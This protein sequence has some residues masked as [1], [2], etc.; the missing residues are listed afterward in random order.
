MN[1]Q[2]PPYDWQNIFFLSLVHVAAVV[3]LAT[4]LPLHGLS[5]AA[6]FV[7]ALMT[8]LT[9]FCISAGYHRLFS[10][11][12]YESHP[13]FRFFLLAFGAGAFQNSALAWATDHRRHHARTDTDLDPYS[14]NGGFWHA[15]VG[16]VLRKTDESITP[17][18]V[19]DLERDPLVMWQA[20]HY[21]L[22]G[23]VTGVIFPT[24]LGWA[25]G[26]A[27][28][29]FV[30]GAA[31]RLMVC[32]H[33][34]FSINSLAHMWGTQPYSDKNSSRDSFVVALISMGEGYHNFHH[35][36]PSDY[37]NGVRRHQFDPTKWILFGLSSVGVVSNLRR[38]SQPTIVRARVRMDERRLEGLAL[39]ADERE[40]LAAVRTAI[41]RATDR[42]HELMSRYET[43]KR[44]ASD[45]ARALLREL[46]A[47]LRAAQRELRAA[48][49]AW[50]ELLRSRNLVPA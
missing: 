25:L 31:V 17:P 48:H 5:W 8:V 50:R 6:A 14:V 12:S 38:T 20:R 7:F 15:H 9:I 39:P 40:K 13:V 37:R 36:F 10:H 42:F 19:R 26:D 45:H 22:I 44:D 43:L 28:G 33:T 41:D 46:R 32:Y 21:P 24:L 1:K 29:G 35:T 11:K 16:W 34:T 23:V 18:P 49:Q 30:M 27:I 4:Y 47:Q 3:G 2:Q